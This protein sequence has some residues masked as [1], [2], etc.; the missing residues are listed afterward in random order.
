MF[1]DIVSNVYKDS[2]LLLF[3]LEVAVNGNSGDILLNPGSY[4]IPKPYSWHNTYDYFGY[5]IA[6]DLDDAL[7]VFEDPEGEAGNGSEGKQFQSID[8]YEK[9][10]IANDF[11]QKDGDDDDFNGDGVEN[12]EGEFFNM[13]QQTAKQ[14][15]K[16]DVKF[17]TMEDS[18]LA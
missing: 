16:E 17:E 11:H 7:A 14:V 12:M 2:G 15:N 8:S 4:K 5:I 6:P 1:C 13:C 10:M 3:A 9:G 18:K